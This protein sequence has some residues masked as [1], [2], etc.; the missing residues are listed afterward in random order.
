M[1]GLQQVVGT[2]VTIKIDLRTRTLGSDHKAYMIRSGKEYHLF[3]RFIEMQAVAPDLPELDIPDGLPPLDDPTINDQIKRARAL[4]DWAM[5]PY[6]RGEDKP[7]ADLEFYKGEEKKPYHGMFVNSAQ[8]V[9]WEI[10]GGSLIYVPNPSFLHNGLFGEVVS[11]SEKRL[12]FGGK[13][14]M[15]GFSFEG[16]RMTDVRHLPMKKLPERLLELK[17]YRVGVSQ[18]RREEQ[19]LL[20]RQYYGDFAIHE[21]RV[22]AEIK[23][24]KDYFSPTDATVVSAF[25]NMVQEN[26]NRLRQVDGGDLVFVDIKEAAFLDWDVDGLLIHAEIDSPGKIQVYSRGL[27]PLVFKVIFSLMLVVPTHDLVLHAQTNDIEVTNSRSPGGSRVNEG[28]NRAVQEGVVSL[29]KLIGAENL[30][31]TIELVKAFNARTG[32]TVDSRVN[33]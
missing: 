4:R 23:T 27:A 31:K 29:L 30:D 33:R 9:L 13:K 24:T 22:Q 28:E 17:K 8:H 11:P 21:G 2:A 3:D 10:P 19:L 12:R 5:L 14:R 26:L 20:Y 15:V 32:G 6:N 25:A 18:L 16:R 7:T 1:R